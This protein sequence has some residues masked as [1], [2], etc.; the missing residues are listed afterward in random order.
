MLITVGAPLPSSPAIPW[1]FYQGHAGRAVNIIAVNGRAVSGVVSTLDS[2]NGSFLSYAAGSPLAAA[3]NFPFSL[4]FEGGRT[5]TFNSAPVLNGQRTRAEE[6][7][8]NVLALGFLQTL[9]ATFHDAQKQL[10]F[11]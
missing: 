2:G 4:T 8:H 7:S 6:Y 9:T 10:Y 1:F 3:R 5:L 11:E